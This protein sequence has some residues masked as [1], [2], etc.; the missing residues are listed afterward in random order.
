MTVAGPA[1]IL[2]G[3]SSTAVAFGAAWRARMRRWSAAWRA[4]PVLG[5][6]V[7]V[8]V[9]LLLLTAT[10]TPA[11]LDPDGDVV[12]PLLVLDGHWRDEGWAWALQLGLVVPLIWRRRAPMT[13]LLVIAAVCFV[14]WLAG[15]E[16]Y[17]NVALLIALYTVAAAD[18]PCP[19]AVVGAAVIAAAAL[20]LGAQRWAV[21]S[22]A[23]TASVF[24]MSTMLALPFALGLLV[25]ARR[26]TLAA[27]R[28]AATRAE[29]ARISRE[30][31]DV[32]SHNLSVMVALADGAGM[33][34]DRDPTE[35]KAAIAQVSRTGRDA[36]AEMRRLLD[37]L[38]QP[39]DDAPLR[40]QPGLDD[41]PE[42]AG[43][44]R[45][46]G[47]DVRL[48]VEPGVVLS[49]GLALTV[50]RVVQESLTNVLKHAPTAT[51][52]VVAVHRSASELRIAIDDDGATPTVNGRGDG[53]GL[54]GMAERVARYGG[55]VD[56]GPTTDGGWRVRASV[57]L[58]GDAA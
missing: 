23:A 17:G 10:T 40:P 42:L 41:L 49:D 11:V 47:L 37:V 31:H 3:M 51:R 46:A 27:T 4:R 54:R 14:Q 18:E 20:L 1:H 32:V 26:R 8:A 36:L 12:T 34:V 25:R 13:V 28:D 2:S 53:R 9:L 58:E 55:R 6:A 15:P 57:P 39:E 19:R 35:A 29:R 43:A 38:Q 45:A 56:A 52:A 50:H 33:T 48:D 30:M 21:G 16:L 44:V 7:L 5:D 24:S 22:P